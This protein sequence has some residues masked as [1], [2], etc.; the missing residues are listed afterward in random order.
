MPPKSVIWAR[1]KKAGSLLAAQKE[2]DMLVDQKRKLRAAMAKIQ[3][4]KKNAARRA[5]ALKAKAAKVSLNDLLQML[6]MKAFVLNEEAKEKTGSSSA[7]STDVWI[8]KDP[9]EAFQM[10]S[11]LSSSMEEQQVADFANLLRTDATREA[12]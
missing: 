2:T 6:M 9:K 8:P 11:D 3:K 5:K 12:A 10:I 4:G 7:S 1:T